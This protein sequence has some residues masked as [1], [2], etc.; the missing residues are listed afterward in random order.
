MMT[1]GVTKHGISA[2]RVE[3]GI[4]WNVLAM[5]EESNHVAM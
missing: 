5:N 2:C 3:F 4:G 1:E